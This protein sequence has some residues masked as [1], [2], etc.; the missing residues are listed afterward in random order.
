MRH[1]AP[2]TPLIDLH[3]A[4]TTVLEH[5]LEGQSSGA[6]P[7]IFD[8]GTTLPEKQRRQYPVTVAQ[9]LYSLS[10]ISREAPMSNVLQH[11]AVTKCSRKCPVWPCNARGFLLQVT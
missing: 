6:A 8:L 1:S 7:F 5:W 10:P 2:S 4:A 3:A 11:L 9:R